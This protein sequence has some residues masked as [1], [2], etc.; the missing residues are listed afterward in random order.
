MRSYVNQYF[1]CIFASIYFCQ[2][3]D[4]SAT[5][6]QA[7]FILNSQ[8]SLKVW[9]WLRL[10]W[11][12]RWLLWKMTP[13]YVYVQRLADFSAYL[14]LFILNSKTSLQV[15]SWYCLF[16]THRILCKFAPGTVYFELRDFSA[17]LL[18]ALFILNSK[19]SLQ[20]CWCLFWTRRLL[21]KFAPGSAYFE[22]GD[23]STS[24]L[25]AQFILN[26]SETSLQVFFWLSLFWTT[27]R[28]LCKFSPGPACFEQLGDSLKDDFW[29]CLFWTTRRLLRKLS[30]LGAS[31][32]SSGVA[33]C[34]TVWN[35]IGAA[36]LARWCS[37]KKRGN[38]LTDTGNIPTNIAN[39]LTCVSIQVQVVQ[40]TNINSEKFYEYR[41]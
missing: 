31:S 8:T 11:T 22:L 38:H 5:L 27:Q 25:L 28:L 18:L 34:G 16:W 37:L 2:L 30:R 29:L 35:A 41:Y 1:E 40:A 19:T 13:S 26:N 14:L 39:K 7:L 9:S 15:C 12:T 32:P 6:L 36:T 21:C 33:H 4:F 10:S 20:L 3:V 17:S 24:F 23:F